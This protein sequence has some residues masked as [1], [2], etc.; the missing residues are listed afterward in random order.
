MPYSPEN[1]PLPHRAVLWC[2]HSETELNQWFSSNFRAE[3]HAYLQSG[4]FCV[5]NN[6]N[7][8]QST[9][10]YKGNGEAFPLELEANEIKWFQT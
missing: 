4:K 10:I 5:V 9:T 8:P 1:S 3:V 2:T 6:T 7:Q